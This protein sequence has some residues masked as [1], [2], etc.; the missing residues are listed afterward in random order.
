M[1]TKKGINMK[2]KSIVLVG[3][4]FASHLAIANVGTISCQNEAFPEGMGST[5]EL[6]VSPSG[7]PDSATLYLND[8]S[9][10]FG[11]LKT[12]GYFE[13]MP[14]TFNENWVPIIFLNYTAGVGSGQNGSEHLR[15]IPRTM[16]IYNFVENFRLNRTF[17]LGV[18]ER[19]NS[20]QK[21]ESHFTYRC[22]TQ[23]KSLISLH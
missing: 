3:I 15:L 23:E 8:P 7:L 22:T 6:S 10:Y 19:R 2:I 20:N 18:I 13:G 21:V 12:V 16:V 5:L 9:S 1:K 14:Q 4:V 11:G 17:Q